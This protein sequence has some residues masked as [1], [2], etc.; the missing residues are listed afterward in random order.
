M[1]RNAVCTSSETR[2]Q[3]FSGTWSWPTPLHLLPQRNDDSM[4]L[5]VWDPTSERD[6]R[7]LMPI[8]TPAYPAMNS[9]YNV[10]RC[11]MVRSVTVMTH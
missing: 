5:S 10:T 2:S 7:A 11:T 8:I 9:T 1:Q 4:G 3:L 6:R